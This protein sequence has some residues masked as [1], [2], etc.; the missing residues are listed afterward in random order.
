LTWSDITHNSVC[1]PS[2]LTFWRDPEYELR[3]PFVILYSASPEWLIPFS[4]SCPASVASAQLS[5]FS[6]FSLQRMR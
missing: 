6:A 3:I 5:F 4:C 2:G 1:G